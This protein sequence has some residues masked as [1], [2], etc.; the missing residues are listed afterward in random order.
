MPKNPLV[1]VFGYP[2]DNLSN[3]AENYRNNRLCPFHNSSGPNCTKF[4]VENP[5]GVCSIFH[6]NTI[7]VTCPIRFRQNYTVLADAGKFF[8]GNQK[9]LALTEVRLNG[10]DGTSAGNID[11]VLAVLDGNKKI[12]DFGAIEIQAVYISGNVSNVFNAYMEN[13]QANH[14]IE[15]PAKGYPKPDYLSSSRKR[16]APQL[17]FKGGILHQ[18]GKKMAVVVHRGFF[19]RLP[20]LETVEPK[21]AEIAWL[22]YDLVLDKATNTYQMQLGQTRYTKFHT[23][24]D[25]I[26]TPETGDMNKFTATLEKR[27]TSGKLFGEPPSSPMEPSVEPMDL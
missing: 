20:E 8:F 7:V 23:A 19:E 17:I 16:L 22:I 10:K 15:L 27:I 3:V 24:L 5:L 21:E 4:S 18:W 26:I 2:T 11:I 9:F 1:E 6:G 12:L 25:R 13:P 14:K